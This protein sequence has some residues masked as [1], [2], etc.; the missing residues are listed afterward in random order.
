MRLYIWKTTQ[1][2]TGPVIAVK[3]RISRKIGYGGAYVSYEPATWKGSFWGSG[4]SQKY[5]TLFES[6]H[7]DD[8]RSKNNPSFAG[9]SMQEKF[10]QMIQILETDTK[11]PDEYDLFVKSV[12]YAAEGEVPDFAEAVRAVRAL[13]QLIWLQC[14]GIADVGNKGFSS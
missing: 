9:S 7:E 13:V 10:R 3:G 8:R 11:Y 2:P 12:S 6:M 4:A 14:N 1:V 5:C